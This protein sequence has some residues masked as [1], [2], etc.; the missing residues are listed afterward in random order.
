MRFGLSMNN[1]LSCDVWLD[2][3]DEESVPMVSEN[4]IFVQL[5]A[6]VK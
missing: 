2:L 6:K 4:Q 5:Q 3:K 1:N